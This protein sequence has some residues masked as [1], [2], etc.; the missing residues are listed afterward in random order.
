MRY[1]PVSALSIHM[2]L[3]MRHVKLGRL[4]V[5]YSFEIYVMFYIW[6]NTCVPCTSVNGEGDIFNTSVD[7]LENR[8]T[9]FFLRKS[10]MFLSLHLNGNVAQ[11][12]PYYFY[13]LFHSVCRLLTPHDV[14]ELCILTMAVVCYK[15]TC[16]R[17]N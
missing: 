15:T 12:R 4:H 2:C 16:T 6:Q 10:L 14:L 13:S 3:A 11:E 9:Y 17:S 1:R 5:L 8:K 7:N